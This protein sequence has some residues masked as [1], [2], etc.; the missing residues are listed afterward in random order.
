MQSE[1][2][3]V[4]SEGS[5]A[6]GKVKVTVNGNREITDVKIDDGI[7]SEKEKLQT[8]IK[9]AYKDATGKGFQLKVAK[10]MQELGGLDALKGFGL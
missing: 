5:A 2:A 8:A 6:F 1:L 4:I 10:K 3:T 9:E 7:L